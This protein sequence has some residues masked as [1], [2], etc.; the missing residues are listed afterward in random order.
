MH[1]CAIVSLQPVKLTAGRVASEQ[2]CVRP[3]YFEC[4]WFISILFQFYLIRFDFIWF[5][6]IVFD[7]CRIYLGFFYYAVH[8]VYI[9]YVIRS[10]LSDFF[11][12]HLI[13]TQLQSCS[14]DRLHRYHM[15]QAR[16]G[17]KL[18]QIEYASAYIW[19]LR[20]FRVVRLP[21]Q[22]YARLLRLLLCCA[23]APTTV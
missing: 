22:S 15:P 10:I 16:G 21:P 8:S 9:Y 12:I 4:V 5:V 1:L 19:A 18:K 14:D 3:I 23:S 11:L 7:L 13:S 6:S 2:Y 17:N 20:V